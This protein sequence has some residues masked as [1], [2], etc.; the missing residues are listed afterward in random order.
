MSVAMGIVVLGGLGIAVSGTSPP[1]HTVV[2]VHPKNPIE[3]VLDPPISGN[4]AP[5]PMQER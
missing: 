4:L 1:T 5:I 3:I 2:P